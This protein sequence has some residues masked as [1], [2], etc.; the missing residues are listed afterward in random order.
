MPSETTPLIQRVP[1]GEQ[2]QRYPYQWLRRA[3]TI[4]LVLA[5]IIVPLIFFLVPGAIPGKHNRVSSFGLSPP[6]QWPKPFGL[7]Y[8]ELQKVLANTPEAEQ[9]REWSKYYTAGPH[10]MGKNKSQAEWTRDRWYDFGVIDSQVVS[11]E[12]LANYPKDHRLA[13][14]DTS[15]DQAKI[16][17]EA[18]LEEDVLDEDHTSGLKDRVP[19]FHGY[20]ATGNVTA[21]YVYANYGS[22]K[23]FEDL[24]KLGVE[25]EG[26]IAL[27]RYGGIFRGLK[28]ER[29]QQLGMIG[30]VMYSDPG[31]DPIQDH[32]AKGQ[33]PNGP[34]R[35]PSSVQ[36]GSVQF[37]S[38]FFGVQ[39]RTIH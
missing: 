10:L 35:N 34:A 26:L 13:L 28:V 1:V 20:S 15:K 37:L 5:L 21:R 3:C 33:Y 17:F 23:D 31:D 11:Y 25:L 12:V 24:E 29:A 30:V 27:V 4:L 19:T 39:T 9:A 7:E 36:R 18:S 22:I 16:K 14:L 32:D 2:R 38:E 8:K 6:G